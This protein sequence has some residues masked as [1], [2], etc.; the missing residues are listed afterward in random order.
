M[1][2]RA[3][4]AHTRQGFVRP[5]YDSWFNW[6]GERWEYVP[7]TTHKLCVSNYG[8]IFKFTKRKGKE[9]R[10]QVKPHRTRY[11]LEVRIKKKPYFQKTLHLLVADL[12]QLRAAK[13]MVL[14]KDGDKWNPRLSNLMIPGGRT[15]WK[16]TETQKNLCFELFKQ[17]PQNIIVSELAIR[18][19]VNYKTM[20]RIYKE[21]VNGNFINGITTYEHFAHEGLLRGVRN[22]HMGRESNL[23]RSEPGLMESDA[24]AKC[25]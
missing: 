22:L 10:I 23:L 25:T 13:E 19:M 5:I 9:N 2:K 12:F 3:V 7:G 16:I 8:R 18:Y 17:Y 6:P 14:F 4:Y 21:F 15:R 20:W 1:A 24:R 11:G